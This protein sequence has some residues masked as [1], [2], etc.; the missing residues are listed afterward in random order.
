MKSILPTEETLEAFR[1][2]QRRP[3]RGITLANFKAFRGAQHFPLKRINVL[4]G[5]NSAGKSSLIHALAYLQHANRTG[6]DCE[7]DQVDLGWSRVRLGGWQNLVHGHVSSEPIRIAVDLADD[8][9][10]EWKFGRVAGEQR[11]KVIDCSGFRHGRMQFV[12]RN[13]ACEPHDG[14]LLWGVGLAA[15]SELL[16]EFRAD[17]WKFLKHPDGGTG[18]R[19]E[20]S[21]D[22]DWRLVEST[23]TDLFE[24]WMQSAPIPDRNHLAH[25]YPTWFYPL[26]APALVP[27]AYES[28]EE[29]GKRNRSAE[30][31]QWSPYQRGMPF[32]EPL[33]WQHRPNAEARERLLAALMGLCGGRRGDSWIV[34]PELTAS[35]GS[36]ELVSCMEAET[37]Y[38]RVGA[39]RIQYFLEEWLA[40]RFPDPSWYFPGAGPVECL[41]S[42]FL[43]VDPARN[44]PPGRITFS[45]LGD[46]PKWRPWRRLLHD[47]ELRVAVN[48]CLRT[49]KAPYEAVTR[50]VRTVVYRSGSGEIEADSAVEELVFRTIGRDDHGGEPVPRPASQQPTMSHHDIGYG[51]STVLPIVIALAASERK[52]ITIEQ[53]EQHVHPALQA[54][55]ADLVIQA[56]LKP[57]IP[58]ELWELSG[59]VHVAESAAWTDTWS[60]ANQILLETHSEHLILRILRRIRE[61]TR[62]KLPEGLPAVTPEDV[63][64]LYVEPGPEG[65]QVRELRIDPQGR[66][67]DPWPGGFFEERLDE[68]F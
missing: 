66:F 52:F 5:P 16:E 35:E 44:R 51:I 56:A 9:R 42:S 46:E 58:I 54:E 28:A 31:L 8:W 34:D 37:D 26:P 24:R 38:G 12:A 55:L 29:R 23:F 22:V 7:P 32:Y 4:V 40:D 64:V 45:D 33:D 43:H 57:D 67:M 50:E 62:G 17:L 15:G 1:E 36:V 60:K 2:A 25:D 3:V 68:L 53:P 6:G 18:Q 27:Y 20:H 63:A 49:L 13:F 10:M 30:A 19:C 39:D 47:Q 11:A 65:A 14:P 21:A 61:T 59:S 41:M 48:R